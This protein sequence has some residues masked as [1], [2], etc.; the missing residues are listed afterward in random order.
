MQV[1]LSSPWVAFYHKLNALFEKDPD[2][3]VTY[4]EDLVQVKIY[5]GSPV[6]ADALARVLP[7]SKTFG[8][9]ELKITVIPANT[10]DS[11][12]F[13]ELFKLAFEG[14]EIVSS[15]QSGGTPMT[16][17]MNYVVFEKEVVQYFNDDLS[18]YGGVKSTLYQDIAKE[19]FGDMEEAKGVFFCTDI[20]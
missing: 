14:N 1:N 11:L 18:T 16:Q 8:N 13:I 12:S 3:R 15:I 20:I 9:V 5:V 17:D 6:K 2:V 7:A 10:M 4:D 19:V